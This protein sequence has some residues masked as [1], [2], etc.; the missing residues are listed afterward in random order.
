MEKKAITQN[1]E[2]KSVL[3]MTLTL[4][5]APLWQKTIPL[6]RNTPLTEIV[7]K[8]TISSHLGVN[9]VLRNF[10]ALTTSLYARTDETSFNFT[11]S[12]MSEEAKKKKCKAKTKFL[13]VCNAILAMVYSQ[14]LWALVNVRERHR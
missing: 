1:K 12:V 14:V 8:N 7:L 10:R 13:Q 11:L 4:I 6:A 3:T 5:I 2:K 9:V